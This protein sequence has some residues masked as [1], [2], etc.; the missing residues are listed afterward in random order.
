MDEDFI[1][2]LEPGIHLVP[3]KGDV[4]FQV[5]PLGLQIAPGGFFHDPVAD[6]H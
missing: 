5:G 2:L 6:L 4:V 1:V 3:V